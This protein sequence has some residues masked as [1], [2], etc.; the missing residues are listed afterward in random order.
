M[1]SDREDSPAGRERQLLG[2]RH[3][4]IGLLM[5][6]VS[7]AAYALRPQPYAK[8]VA[9]AKLD[10]LLPTDV[11]RWHYV[12]SSG[13]LLPPPD[14]LSERIYDGVVTRVYAAPGESPVMLLLAYSAIQD[15]M[16]QVHRPEFCYTAGGFSLSP[17]K[18]LDVSDA[19]DDRVGGSTFLAMSSQSSEEVLYITRLGDSFPQSWLEQRSA[20]L[21]ANLRGQVPDGML[22]RVSA[23]RDGS[24]NLLSKLREFLVEFDRASPG[25]LR[26][27]IFGKPR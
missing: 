9:A 19:K 14:A 7:G 10:G 12:A 20:V 21:R 1:P 11:G 6:G 23:V 16:L 27:I 26:T 25:E 17:T 24:T 2:R 13:V 22:L 18:G 15:G 8:R 4:L 5:A 3:F